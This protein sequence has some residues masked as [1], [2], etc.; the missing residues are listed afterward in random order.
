MSGS[1]ANLFVHIKPKQLGPL[2]EKQTFYSNN[3]YMVEL[4]VWCFCK[5]WTHRVFLSL[6]SWDQKTDRHI[7]LQLKYV[8]TPVYLCISMT[9]L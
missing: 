2:G 1:T 6:P 7:D 3:I 8:H 4:V 9:V 5:G